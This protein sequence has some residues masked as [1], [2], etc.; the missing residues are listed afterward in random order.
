MSDLQN[1]KGGP[2]VCVLHEKYAVRVNT[3]WGG[4]KILLTFIVIAFS[5]VGTIM[6]DTRASSALYNTESIR[7]D[8]VISEKFLALNTQLNNDNNAIIQVLNVISMNQKRSMEHL[9]L[10]YISPEWVVKNGD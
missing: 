2:D 8:Q 9:D 3:M 5:V 4:F 1:H 6:M 7:R 10:R